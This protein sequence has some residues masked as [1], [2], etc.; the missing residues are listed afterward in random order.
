MRLIAQAML[1]AFLALGYAPNPLVSGALAL[2]APN[3]GFKQIPREQVLEGLSATKA[4]FGLRFTMSVQ[5]RTYQRGALARVDLTM[6]NVSKRSIDI[7]KGR[8]QLGRLWAMDFDVSP[9]TRSFNPAK[10]LYPP[11]VPSDPDI[12][13]WDCHPPFPTAALHPGEEVRHSALVPLRGPWLLE[14]A[15]ITVEHLNPPSNRPGPQQVFAFPTR[16]HVA[17]IPGNSNA[18]PRILTSPVVHVD[19]TEP[20]GATGPLYYQYLMHCQNPDGSFY[21]DRSFRWQH[22]TG[23]TVA[24]NQPSFCTSL[25]GW[26]V[27]GGW[28]N[29]P[30]EEADYVPAPSA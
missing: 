17:L 22:V 6:R 2:R 1:F 27:V 21:F 30:L 13:A 4:A 7:E 5:R 10:D 28:E 18:T 19:F 23:T 16:L 12:L 14:M 9:G 29:Y 20:S 11:A 15:A 24:L 3:P 25:L 8:C 26:K